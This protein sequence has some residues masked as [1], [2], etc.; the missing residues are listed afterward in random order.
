MRVAGV[1]P[2]TAITGYAFLSLDGSRICPDEFGCIRTDAGT[3]PAER[4]LAIYERFSALVDR[5]RPD[6]VALER[7]FFNANVKT[8]MS[9]AHASGVIMLV[10]AQRGIE[11]VSYTPLEV[12]MA[13]AGYGRAEKRQIQEMVKVMLN[14][15]ER[16]SP[17]DVA[18]AIAIAICHLNSVPLRSRLEAHGR[19][20]RGAAPR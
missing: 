12:K 4:L 15:S 18:D 8:A 2:G 9:V 19:E 5:Y 16:P 14:L 20:A 6:V 10:A 13:I 11:L 7:V 1:D 17:D 3:P